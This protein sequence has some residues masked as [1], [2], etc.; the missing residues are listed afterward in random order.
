MNPSGKASEEVAAKWLRAHNFQILGRNRR[1]FGV[2]IDII[3]RQNIIQ[4]VYYLVEVK[5]IRRRR[6]E[7]GYPPL[8]YRQWERYLTAYKHWCS[9]ISRLPDIRIS[10][11]LI[12]E[13]L[14]LIDFIPGYFWPNAA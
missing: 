7:S 1:F 11:L 2:E 13:K 3:A 6:Y 10:L 12:D 8:S 14:E 4:P 9:E 5:K